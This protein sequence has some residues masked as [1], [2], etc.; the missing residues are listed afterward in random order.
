MNW[1]RRLSP[2][3]EKTVRLVATCAIAAVLGI[4]AVIVENEPLAYVAVG[5]VLAGILAGPLVARVLFPP[6]GGR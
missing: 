5:I 6:D 1:V 3:A 4:T 2:R